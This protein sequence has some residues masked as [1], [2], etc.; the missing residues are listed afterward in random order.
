MPVRQSKEHHHQAGK[1]TE[2]CHLT[3]VLRQNGYPSNFIRSSPIPSRRDVETTEA[4]LP[5]EGRRPP[6]VMLPYTEGVSEVCRKFGMKVVF[7]S[8]LSLRSMLTKVKDTLALE[9]R[10]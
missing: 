4:P 3:E 2:E 7:R 10:S 9:K 6:L 5:E 8:G 1:L